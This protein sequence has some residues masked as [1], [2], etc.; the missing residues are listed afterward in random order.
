MQAACTVYESQ[1]NIQPLQKLFIMWEF[2]LWHNPNLKQ[3]AHKPPKS[4]VQTDMEKQSDLLP[5]SQ[6]HINVP[7][8]VST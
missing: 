7:A 3:M 5:V 2:A 8:I 1:S 6:A 4:S